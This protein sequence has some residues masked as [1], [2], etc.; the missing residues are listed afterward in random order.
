MRKYRRGRYDV[1]EWGAE[2]ESRWRCLNEEVGGELFV[3]ES[4]T[5][6]V[7]PSVV[8]CEAVQ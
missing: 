4:C 2:L 1:K 7:L 6:V 8:V 5:L 3:I